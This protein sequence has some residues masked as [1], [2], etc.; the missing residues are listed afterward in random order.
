MKNSTV[1]AADVAARAIA[2][3]DDESQRGLTVRLEYQLSLTGILGKVLTHLLDQGKAS[4]SDLI[5]V[6]ILYSQLS[7]GAENVLAIIAGLR[8]SLAS[9]LP[10]Q[11]VPVS[12]NSPTVI[13]Q[14][15]PLLKD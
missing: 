8:P 1:D 9:Q 15:H 3:F 12:L 14:S 10:A 5:E 7:E 11:E 13:Q 4:Y 6:Q 2:I